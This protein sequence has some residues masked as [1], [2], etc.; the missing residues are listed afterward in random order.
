MDCKIRVN[1]YIYERISRRKTMDQQLA[2]AL[3]TK[4][5]RRPIDVTEDYY[6]K[7]QPDGS[8]DYFVRVL[9]REESLSMLQA[10]KPV[11]EVA[12]A[13]WL[14]IEEDG[15]WEVSLNDMSTWEDGDTTESLQAFL[16]TF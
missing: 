10:D 8:E 5:F 9:T 11:G 1:A 13:L 2:A 16:T 3:A 14:T 12:D 4:G 7:G 15:T 6:A